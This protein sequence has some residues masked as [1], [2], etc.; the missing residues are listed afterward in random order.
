MRIAVIGGSGHIGTYLIPQLVE[1]GH[2][3]LCVSRG[4]RQPY[5]PHDGWAVVEHVPLD[6]MVEEAAGTFG[7]RLAELKADAV[8]DLTCYTLGSARQLVEALRGNVGHFL[9]CGTIW[10]HGHSVEVPTTED[11]PRRPISDYGRQKAAIEEYLLGEA[12]EH[13]FPATLLHPGHLVGCGWLPLNPAANFNPEVFEKLAQGGAVVLPNFG[14]ETVHHVHAADVAQAFTN[15]VA[16]RS[17][18][19]GESFHIVSPA[20][21]TLRGFAE[22]VAGWFGKEANLS[23]LPWNEW[24]ETVSQ[25]DA[26][27]TWDHIARSPNCS[28]AKAQRLL[29]YRPRY[30]SDEAVRESLLWWRSR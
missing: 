4:Q 2:A 11:Q 28:I 20:A 7:S 12:R 10:I 6:R 25:K 30:R 23:F 5:Q 15:A 16:R 1:A 3:V 29:D 19:T 26:E 27:M 21:L 8:I 13:G 17:A 14:L 18:S 24:R 22:R 9:H